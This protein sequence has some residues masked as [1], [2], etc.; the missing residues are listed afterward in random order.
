MEQCRVKTPYNILIFVCSALK[1]LVVVDPCSPSAV[2][3][4]FVYFVFIK[5]IAIYLC[6]ALVHQHP[7]AVILKNKILYFFC[8]MYSGYVDGPQNVRREIATATRK[9]TG[10]MSRQE[11]IHQRFARCTKD[12]SSGGGICERSEEKEVGA[13]LLG[14]MP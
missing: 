2:L 8:G 9:I 14:S 11:G 12:E 3:S 10:R 5:L 1:P 4:V 13:T 7:R 6:C